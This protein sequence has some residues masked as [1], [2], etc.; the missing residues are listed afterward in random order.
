MKKFVIVLIALLVL[1]TAYKGFSWYKDMTV[2]SG[3]AFSDLKAEAASI[4]GE[5]YAGK[6]LFYEDTDFGRVSIM[7]DM[8]VS[9][10]D[11][12]ARPWND[13]MPK[14]DSRGFELS[15]AH[16]ISIYDC[17]V[18]FRRYTVL[19]G[20]EISETETHKRI[21][22]KAYEDNDY[23]SS[24]IASLDKN[25][26]E[27]AFSESDEIYNDLDYQIERACNIIKQQ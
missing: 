8:S 5:E 27:I 17:A 20:T 15:Q 23:R 3:S 18:D 12:K 1:L 25:S 16:W 24:A 21:N 22:Y 14:Y 13:T 9:F 6:E 4:H 7:E 10:G 19:D 26:A 11:G 2:L